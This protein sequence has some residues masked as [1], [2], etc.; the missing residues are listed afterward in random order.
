M[1]YAK[2]LAFSVVSGKMEASLKSG[3]GHV[4]LFSVKRDTDEKICFVLFFTLRK[5]LE[6]SFGQSKFPNTVSG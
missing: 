1:V 4:R 6:S 2:S 3:G 5:C